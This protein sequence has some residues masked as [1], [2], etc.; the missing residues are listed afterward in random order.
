MMAYN[1]TRD[2]KGNLIYSEGLAKRRLENF[3]ACS[4][5]ETIKE[6]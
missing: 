2:K 5:Y 4:S 1:K 3:L 6:N